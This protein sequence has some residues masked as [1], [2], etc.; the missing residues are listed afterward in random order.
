MY[1]VYSKPACS[2]CDR[3]KN[4]LTSKG[5]PFMERVIDVGQPKIDGKEYVPL[6]DVKKLFPQARSVPLFMRNDQPLGG[7]RDLLLVLGSHT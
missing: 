4:L 1:I 7:L 6:E 2:E 5:I 3:A